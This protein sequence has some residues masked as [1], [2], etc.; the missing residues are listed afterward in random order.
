MDGYRAP[1][2]TILFTLRHVA[3]LHE[4]P[5]FGADEAAMLEPVLG[6]AAR[7]AQ[8]VLTPLDAIGD[9]S[10]ARLE[11]GVV[12]TP[13]GYAAAWRRWAEAG[14]IGLPVEPGHGGQ[15]LPWAVATAVGEMI[16][17]ANLAWS[18]APLLTQGAIEAIARHAAPALRE[19]WLPAMVEGRVSGA[20]ALTEPQA[21]TDLGAIRTRARPDGD[22]FRIDGEK[23]FI[24][25]ADHDMTENI[26]QL[27]LARLPDAPPGPKGISL[28]LVP[29]ILP[30]GVRNDWRVTRLEPK[31][32]IHG[33]PTCAV[34]YG[35]DGGAV[36]WLVGPPHQ[37]LRCMF[38]M[39]NNARLAVARE[40]VGVAERA[41]QQALA[42]TRSRVQGRRDG[43]PARLT[44][45]PDVRRQLATMHAR[46]LAM[47]GLTLWTAVL[48]D[49]SLRAPDPD[50]R[51]LAEER[52]ALLTPIAKAWCT[53][54]AVEVCSTA[55][56]LHGGMGFVEAS[57]IAQRYRDVRITPIY[58]GANGI[59]A[60]DLVL[61][62]LP[63][64]GGRA[65]LDL[66][67][68]LAAEAGHWREAERRALLPALDTLGR[69]TR[70]VQGSDRDDAMAAS[71]PFLELCGEVLAGIVLARGAA[72]G[73]PG[74]DRIA[75][76]HHRQLLPRA[77]A[78]EAAIIAG[79]ADLPGILADAAG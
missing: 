28:F 45:W 49:R 63:L 67:E 50:A 7:F 46:V 47:R 55:L 33:S 69:L 16:E 1:V 20:M 11:N 25:F 43:Q 56:Q 42:W 53:D 79:Q 54:R 75:A 12:R 14:W 58:E 8:E 9:R 32:G 29:K 39:M 22:V 18:I 65:V 10:G 73:G 3:R 35:G 51:A 21:G 6:E 31:L 23:I 2:E 61:R 4:V 72:A 36:G 27:V 64:R 71:V 57:G 66:L 37:G 59:Q 30:E 13:E 62:K 70:H 34:S 68:D 52:L 26:V 17:A 5:G 76:F 38:T 48:L 24:S 15:G 77:L 19:R 41:R 44:D 78:N 60:Q 40:A 74:W